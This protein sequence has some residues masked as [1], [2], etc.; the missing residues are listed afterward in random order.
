[1]LKPGEDPL[2]PGDTIKIV[3]AEVI[4]GISYKEAIDPNTGASTVGNRG[5]SELLKKCP[6]CP[7]QL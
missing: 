7:V 5:Y 1:M 2:N 6:S 3:T 4:G